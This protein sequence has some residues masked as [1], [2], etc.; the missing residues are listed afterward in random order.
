MILGFLI[1]YFIGKQFYN[2]ADRY[3]KNN[4]LYAILSVVV[5]YASGFILGI[6]LGVF[7]IIFEWNVDWDNKFGV[8]LLA[9][10]FGLLSVYGFYLL[11]ESKWKKSVKIIKNEIDDIGKPQDDI[12]STKLP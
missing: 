6:V 11:L 3:S 12:D 8:N 2:L 1:I 4:W 5:Y 7:D 10:P 9:I